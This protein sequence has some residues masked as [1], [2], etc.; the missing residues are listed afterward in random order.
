MQGAGCARNGRWYHLA[1]AE[2]RGGSGPPQ[3]S[4]QPAGAPRAQWAAA[5]LTLALRRM[6][7]RVGPIQ[8]ARRLKVSPGRVALAAGS[9]PRS[10]AAVALPAAS[11]VTVM[12]PCA[13]AVVH[14]TLTS[15]PATCVP[16]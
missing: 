14:T 15:A 13:R 9:A 2:E 5:R 1:G 7:S 16:T 4:M 11:V 12:L 10:M 6:A 3:R 8:V